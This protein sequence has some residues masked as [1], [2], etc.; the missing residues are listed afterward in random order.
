MA[1]PSNTP[2]TYYVTVVEDTDINR[3]IS[4]ATLVTELQFN[5]R[6]PMVGWIK[7][8]VIDNTQENQP[9]LKSVLVNTLK[10]L[11][12]TCGCSRV[13]SINTSLDGDI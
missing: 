10:D 2:G 11:G 13:E 6:C 4:T 3:V 5:H 8:V 7:D 12:E 1:S 9:Q